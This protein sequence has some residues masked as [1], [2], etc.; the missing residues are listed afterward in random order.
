MGTQ[1]R[2]MPVPADFAAPTESEYG[3]CISIVDYR[4]GEGPVSASFGGKTPEWAD[5]QGAYQ[6]YLVAQGL[7]SE[8]YNWAWFYLEPSAIVTPGAAQGAPRIGRG[9][10]SGAYMVVPDVEHDPL[11]YWHLDG[12]TPVPRGSVIIEFWHDDFGYYYMHCDQ[13]IDVPNPW[14]RASRR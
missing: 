1:Y 4:T 3:S 9:V 13:R 11:R 8:E 5:L 14:G 2:S 6:R 10:P 12:F 7:T